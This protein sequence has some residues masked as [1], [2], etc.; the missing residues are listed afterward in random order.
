MAK[1]DYKK[2]YKKYHS[3]RKAKKARAARNKARR[4]MV[5]AG[6]VRKGDG[7]EVDHK[8]PLSKGGSNGKKNLRVVKR[9]KN[10]QDGQKLSV[11]A[12]KKNKKELTKAQKSRLRK[13]KA[14]HTK[15]HMQMMINMMRDGKSFSKAHKA[16]MKKVGK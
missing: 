6:R 5:K 11:K 14:H 13:H 16:A 10:R 12:R 1:R 15:K 4:Q 8:R 9:K 3:S 2:I 7:K